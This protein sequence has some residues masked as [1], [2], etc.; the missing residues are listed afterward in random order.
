MA[1]Q[2]VEVSLDVDFDVLHTSGAPLDAL[3][4]RFGRVNRLGVRPPAPTVVHSPDYR[5]RRGGGPT[6]YADGVYDA[7]PT[8]LAMDLLTRHDRHI[9]DEREVLGW[10]NEIYTS[11]WGTGWHRAVEQSRE[12]F[13]NAF[14]NFAHPFDDRSRLAHRFDELFDGAEAILVD[15]LD[16]YA[17]LLLSARGRAG[18]LLA[19]EL[20][21]PLPHYTVARCRWDSRLNVRVLNADYDPGHGLGEIRARTGSHYEPGEVL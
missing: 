10:L 21:I 7:E 1:T 6:E 5:S 12:N 3:L 20:L 4:Q 9:V 8:R 15:D 18:R 2:V 19:E 14:L 13:R 11:D 16:E 17:D